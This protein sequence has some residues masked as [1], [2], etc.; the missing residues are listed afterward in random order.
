[1]SL[2]E[3]EVQVDELES[4]VDALEPSFASSDREEAVSLFD[5]KVS[6]EDEKKFTEKSEARQDEDDELFEEDKDEDVNPGEDVPASTGLGDEPEVGGKET[7]TR[8]VGPDEED[9]FVSGPRGSNKSA[10]QLETQISE[11]EDSR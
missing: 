11:E 10:E 8:S 7:I 4:R 5:G 2:E 3:L 9:K 1:M 6:R